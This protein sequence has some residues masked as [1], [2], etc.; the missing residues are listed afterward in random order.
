MA[1]RL[2]FPVLDLLQRYAL[3]LIAADVAHEIDVRDA[4]GC[5][6]G[7]RERLEMAL[8]RGGH[9]MQTEVHRAECRTE[10]SPAA[11]RRNAAKPA[12]GRGSSNKRRERSAMRSRSAVL[13]PPSARSSSARRA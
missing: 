5:G 7:G 10:S 3:V 2:A 12:S 6:G 11:P 8:H 9:A 13:W 1:A 4:R